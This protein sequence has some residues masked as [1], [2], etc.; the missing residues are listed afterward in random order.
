M[1]VNP[2][3]L[4]AYLIAKCQFYGPESPI[5]HGCSNVIELLD[6][7]R[8]A[9]GAQLAQIDANLSW[10]VSRLEKL[11]AEYV[12]ENEPAGTIRQ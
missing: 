8:S 4:H 9:T 7:R 10:Q 5:G 12:P 3:R 6:N 2:D 1:T 11:C